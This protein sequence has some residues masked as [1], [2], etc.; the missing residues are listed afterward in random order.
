MF[1]YVARQPIV[2][3]SQQLYAYELLFRDGEKNCF[4]NISPDEAT[5]RILAASHLNVGLEAVT[6]GA[7]AF[8]NFH[9]DTLLHRFPTSLDPK[10]VVIEIT[11]TV[12]VSDELVDACQQIKAQGYR[13][14]LDDYDLE[15]K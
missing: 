11:E 6:N 10:N 3:T 15:E 12:D 14:A 9:T 2:D 13:L 8:I 4:P 7:L 5:S 1:A